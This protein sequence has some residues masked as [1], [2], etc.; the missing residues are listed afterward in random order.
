MT[1]EEILQLRN[2]YG[3]PTEGYQSAPTE[4]NVDRTAELDAA[5][6]PEQAPKSKIRKAYDKYAEVTEDF[7]EGFAKGG[8]STLKGLGTIGTDL[9]EGGAG[10]VAGEKGK[11]FVRENT[12]KIY[13]RGSKEEVKAS[14][15]LKPN[16]TAE[17]V[18][19]TTEK[20][21]EFFIPA[22]KVSKV[23]KAT[24]TAI[25]A[26]KMSKAA[27]FGTKVISN[28]A[29]EGAGV[30]VV[31]TAQTADYK[32]GLKDALVSALISVPFKAMSAGK[33]AVA[34]KLTKSAEKGSSQA[35]GATTKANKQLSDKVVPELLK[36]KVIFGSRTGLYEKATNQADEVG[37][38]INE[39]FKALPKDAKV[40]IAPVIKRLEDAKSSF[41]VKG[42][43]TV[44]EAATQQYQALQNLQNEI[45][46]LADDAFKDSSKTTT[47]VNTIKNEMASPQRIIEGLSP[48][49]LA[50]MGG[51]ERLL[52][53]TKDSIV[54]NVR[55]AGFASQADD[56]ARLDTKA[57]KSLD[58]MND[59]ISE[60]LYGKVS[61]DSIRSFRQ[62]LDGVI[63]KSKG[64]F[65]MTGS[66]T[67]KLA[68]QKEGTNAIRNVLADE[69][70][71]I[72]KLNKEFNFW[73]NVQ[74]VVGDTVA[75]TKSQATP[76]S[77]VIAEG[78]GAVTGAVKGGT[79]GNVIL[80]G[81]IYPLLKRAFTSPAWRQASAV[82]KTNLARNIMLGN[83]EMVSQI[84]NR[85]INAGV[86]LPKTPEE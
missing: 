4:I 20:I 43:N 68:A 57:F 46:G 75:R 18:G 83:T 85:I 27:K 82:T 8:L 78:A 37:E 42:T 64:G 79:M 66:E 62:I 19:F 70:P 36:R 41:V 31:S 9:M 10:I 11:Q 23:N 39:A 61:T 59:A 55:G 54:T 71:D 51:M 81:V 28:A 2:K 32:K 84:L 53:T 63:A 22:G 73:K 72:A 40:T 60:V 45:L 3:V 67:A 33:G 58:E 26:S 17:K 6:G 24:N 65:G 5:W 21:A 49:D 35:L 56:I 12:S 80:G 29:T 25:N 86:S 7:S 52:S 15:A 34:E 30:G 77:E 76:V 47:L 69:Y 16:N 44:P 14:E 13:Q 38:Q 74:T 1:N 50:R 48:D